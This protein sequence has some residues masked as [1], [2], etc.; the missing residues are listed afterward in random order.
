MEGVESEIGAG[1]TE[2][3]HLSGENE[4][5]EQPEAD[6]LVECI[7]TVLRGNCVDI[8]GLGVNPEFLEALPEDMREEVLYQHIRER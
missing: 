7:Y 6:T 8:T 5:T 3:P 1:D 2:Q 4:T